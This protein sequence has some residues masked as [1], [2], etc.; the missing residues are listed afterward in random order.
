MANWTDGP[1][2]AP[3]Q[4]PVAF[5]APPGEMLQ[6]P[7]AQP[8]AAAGA[9]L[10]QPA[11]QPPQG[12]VAPLEALVPAVAE[13]SRDPH[14]AFTTT[15]TPMTG[16]S[17]AWGSAHSTTG[18]SDHPGWTP[19]QPLVTSATTSAGGVQNPNPSTWPAP[20]GDPG[21]AAI[22]SRGL[23][24]P[25]PQQAAPSFPQPGTPDWFAPAPQAQW[26]PPDQ[27][28]TVAQMWRGATPGLMIALIVG[29]LVNP[30]SVVLLL[31]AALLAGRVRYRVS[32]I[33]HIFAWSF[34]LLAAVG[35]MGLLNSDLDLGTAWSVL[36][37]WAQV[38]CWV[39]PI[40]VLLQVGA[41][42]RAN[43]PPNQ[44]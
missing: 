16:T 44:P 37:G 36:S 7:P 5:E 13:I 40:I 4:R 30:L 31:V 20:A 32:R 22:A 25:P 27:T 14:S 15:S 41:G 21:A 2:Y 12:A 43:E 38:M 10:E 11:W 33:R 26:R 29:A 9:P 3:T 35:T 39:I 23:N 17:S 42:I 18:M 34:G 28:V 8:N 6:V 24:F 19:D 1:E